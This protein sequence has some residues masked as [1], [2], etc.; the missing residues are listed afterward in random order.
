M[1]TDRPR[2]EASSVTPGHHRLPW[3]S[4]VG[5]GAGLALI[6]ILVA[7]G[8]VST[9][10]TMVGR[11]RGWLALVVAWHSCPLLCDA[12]A[13]RRDYAERKIPWR[14][15]ILVGTLLPLWRRAAAE[16]QAA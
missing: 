2:R 8:D 6:A 12:L 7:R 16:A 10:L 14:Q 4:I 15:D 13:W 3:P 5:L 11:L 1:D 9:I